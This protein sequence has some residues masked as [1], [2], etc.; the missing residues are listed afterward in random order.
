M[1]K[2]RLGRTNLEVSELALGTVELGL[3]YGIGAAERPTEAAA[4][5]LLH[6]ALDQ[7]INL[8]DTARAYGEAE[9]IIGTA[10]KGRRHEY[11][12]VSKVQPRAEDVPRL[13]EESLRK[14]QTDH[15]DIILLHCGNEPSPDDE[16]TRALERCRDA[17][18]V[19]FIG[20]SVY[21]TAA[22]LNA[23]ES[24][25]YDCLEIAYSVLDRRPEAEVLPAAESADIG[26]LAR[27]VL[28]KGALSTRYRKLPD[29]LDGLKR[30]V[31]QLAAIAGSI[32]HLPEFAYRY[33]LGR[34]PPHSAL[35]GTA[36]I[37]ELRTGIGY[38]TRGPLP[39]G[40]VA[41]A[42]SVSV[43]DERWLN[44]GLWPS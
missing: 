28:L 6:F 9:R 33:V 4:A 36:S 3:D 22:P 16:A 1:Q 31:E 2:R 37:D 30:H 12:L 38:A 17:G 21:G 41:A 32:D 39:P 15:I 25:R 35:I 13:V 34:T 23:I 11:V 19:R 24:G 18:M 26:I 14:L 40:Q 7:G 44:P 43:E 29:A 27:S 8:I 5:A 42:R 10:L 20:A